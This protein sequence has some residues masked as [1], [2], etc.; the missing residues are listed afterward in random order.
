VYSVNNECHYSL[1]CVLLY[2]LIKHFIDTNFSFL[3]CNSVKCKVFF[4]DQGELNKLYSVNNVLPLFAVIRLKC[5][6]RV[7]VTDVCQ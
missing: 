6:F 5:A 4:V 3:F 7:S 2:S 1:I